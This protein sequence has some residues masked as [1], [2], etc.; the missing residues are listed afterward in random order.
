MSLLTL[1]K[2]PAIIASVLVVLSLLA[3]ILASIYNIK[4]DSKSTLSGRVVNMNGH[5]I[6]KC[7]LAIQP[8]EVI[9][10]ELCQVSKLSHQ[11]QTDSNGFFN[12]SDILPGRA[13]FVVKPETGHTNRDVEIQSINYAGLTFLRLQTSKLR[14]TDEHIQE[15]NN[16]APRKLS[17]IGGIP[18]QVKG[19]L[20][21]KD[22]II[23]VTPRMCI[24]GQILLSNGTP[25]TNAQGRL[26]LQYQTLDGMNSDDLSFYPT[27]T[28]SDGYFLK[29]VNFP[30]VAIVSVEYN[31]S[32]ATSE[33]IKISSE[34]YRHDLVFRLDLSKEK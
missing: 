23:E 14:V 25:L 12:F 34:Q 33:A 8:L 29:Y 4:D 10:G 2:H 9:N 32:A 17:T 6:P 20:N 19:G 13:Q 5:P 21:L 28:D 1:R 27:Y 31:G 16:V 22:I 30:M 15:V 26:N 11:S 3:L 24:R 18:F 7:R